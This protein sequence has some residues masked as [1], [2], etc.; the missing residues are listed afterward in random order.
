MQSLDPD[1]S[2][3]QALSSA[4][5]RVERRLRLN[6]ALYRAALTAVLALLGLIVW[7]T[8]RWLDTTLPAATALVVL[9]GILAAL[10]LLALLLASV[11]GDPI[12]AE[13]AASEA[14]ARAGLKN[15]LASAHWFMQTPA[16]SEWV[17]AQLRRAARTA[18]G[19][20]PGR[21]IPLHVPRTVLASIVAGL[22]VLIAAWSATPLPAQG[23]ASRE[24]A[25]LTDA[26]RER[27]QALHRL[28]ETLADSEP[29]RALRAA[30][31]TLEGGAPNEQQRRKA[32]AQ[33]QEAVDRLQ[34]EAAATREQ[35]HRFSEMLRGQA[36]M[37]Q[38]AD[39]LAAGDAKRAAEL[40]TGMRAQAGPKAG[41]S[42]SA[43]EPPAGAAADRS[44]QRALME[45]T[46]SAGGAQEHG[47]TTAVVQEAA[48]RLDQIARE[49]DAAKDV[50]NAWQSAKGPELPIRQPTALSANRFAQ[51][52][53]GNGVPS[54]QAGD[55]PMEGGAKFRATAVSEGP[56]RSEHGGGSRAGDAGQTPPDPLLGPGGE[57]LEALL[58]RE[59][60]VVE[61][62]EGND[63]N[64]AWYY[65]ESR[66][67]TAHVERDAVAQRA[68]FA[69]AV[70]G[71]GEGISIQHRQIVKDYF[72]KLREDTR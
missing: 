67:E 29:A 17:A 2:P 68:Q 13:R 70:V 50:N 25:G 60:V 52:A 15:Q 51:Q 8:L 57:R 3:G 24:A 27:L 45:A 37:E 69:A 31:D 59:G 18:A 72:M 49:L 21:V 28:A 64:Q 58:R 20:Q 33:A 34:L 19:L 61:E 35:L 55:T 44:L 9:L 46:E 5:L 12:G 4:L 48:E 39:A 47:A 1:L 26:E 7:R 41:K 30:L 42:A 6:R 56:G 63:E 40:L 54:P 53:Q 62:R 43:P 66:R 22:L 38:V 32:L 16:G 11:A 36:G 65:T 10:A 14:D 23:P 71:S